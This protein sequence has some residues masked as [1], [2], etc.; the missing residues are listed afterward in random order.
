MPITTPLPP[1]NNTD[2]RPLEPL[3]SDREE[4][5]SK[6]LEHFADDSYKIPG[7]EGDGVLHEQE[8]FWLVCHESVYLQV[9]YVLGRRVTSASSVV[10]NA[11]VNALQPDL[12]LSY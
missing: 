1:P 10:S 3:P 12:Y 2:V 5:R 4:K 8:K 11:A 9:L 7:I 6:V